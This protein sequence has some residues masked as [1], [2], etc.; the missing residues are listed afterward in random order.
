M[1]NTTSL[2]VGIY[3]GIYIRT[4]LVYAVTAVILPMLHL[5]HVPVYHGHNAVQCM[6]VHFCHTIVY[7]TGV[8]ST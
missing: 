8:L 5:S 6:Y 2:G 4:M 7:H 3:Y 1:I